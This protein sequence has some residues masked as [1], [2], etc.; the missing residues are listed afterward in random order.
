M[1]EQNRNKKGKSGAVIFIFWGTA[2]VALFL[3][4]GVLLLV[5]QSP[6]PVLRAEKVGGK[7][8]KDAELQ[9]DF[10]WPVS[11]QLEVTVTPQ[12]YGEVRYE[13]MVISQ[14]LARTVYFKPE[15][16]WLAGTTYKVTISNVKS[17]LPSYRQPKE[18]TLVFTTEDEPTIRTVTPSQ[19]EPIGLDTSWQVVLDKAN[20]QLV[21][22]QFV[23]DPVLT[24]EAALSQ[25]K[26]TYTLKPS[27][28]LSQGQMYNL[29]IQKKIVRYHFGTDE[30]A[31]QGEPAAVWEGSW[32]VREAPG[33][34][35]FEPAGVGVPLASSLAV[36]FSKNV[37]LDS[38][39]ENVTIEPAVA[40]QWQTGDYRTITLKPKALVRDTTYTVTLKAGLKT[41]DGG[42]LTEDSV[43]TFTTVGPAKVV[44]SSPAD[45]GQGV[46][47]ASSLQFTFNQ[48]V[49]HQSAEG[50]LNVS[51][52]VDGSVA[53]EGQTMVFKP[54]QP[55]AFNA[56]YTISL[57]PG[58][59]SQTGFASEEEQKFTFSTELSVTKLAVPFHR[60]EHNLSCEVAT[61]VM[62]LAYRGIN[63]SEQTLIEAIGFDSTKKQN[64]V[65][66]NPNVAFVGD[67]DGRQPSTG[68]GVYWQPVAKAAQ[69]YRPA[70][71]FTGGAITDLTSEIKKG[72]PVIVW[73]TAGS[74]RRID[75]QTPQGGTVVA[76]SGEHTRV[77][78]G[79]IGSADNPTKIITLDP[80]SGE[81]YFTK[82]S[83]LAN[84]SVLGYSG[85][86]VE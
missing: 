27:V 86:I 46:S 72:N 37:N 5:N 18:F 1:A 62:V 42:Y 11:R 12:V 57:A 64:G 60:Q 71:W 61:L 80:L 63:V 82:D 70:R 81:K 29:R 16:T 30:V 15:L 48:A 24:A 4:V 3:L 68:Y 54:K 74:G 76:V 84:W 65:W 41:N 66:G 43:H 73:G 23:F 51:P 50:K 2:L 40:G 10:Q 39:R 69:K 67:I 53:W 75:W 9:I 56:T 79:F 26:K 35:K 7:I 25:D 6:T 34:E 38:F 13:K 17:A 8:S 33:V 19:T 55:L 49:D 21:D 22:Y 59:K 31:Y 83:F 85:V 20:D 44:S 14:H 45:H 77:V 52:S 58:V 78:I 47:V 36:V 28:P 32:Q